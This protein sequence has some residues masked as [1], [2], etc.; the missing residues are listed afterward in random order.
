MF[1]LTGSVLG[2]QGFG[3]IQVAVL[4]LLLSAL[5]F[6][7]SLCTRAERNMFKR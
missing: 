4:L 5:L 2:F 7:P 1:I 6:L 3:A